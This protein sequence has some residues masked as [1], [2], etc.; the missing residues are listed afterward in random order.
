MAWQ[1]YEVWN[2]VLVTEWKAQPLYVKVRR[3]YRPGSGEFLS[4]N[5]GGLSE[6]GYASELKENPPKLGDS[7]ELPHHHILLF[8]DPSAPAALRR[9][10]FAYLQRRRPRKQT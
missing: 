9:A 1:A 3:Y 5:T 2:R 6:H 10:V 7:C 4:W 8:K